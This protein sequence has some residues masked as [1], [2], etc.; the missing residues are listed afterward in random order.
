MCVLCVCTG[1]MG[2]QGEQGPQGLEGEDGDQGAC[3]L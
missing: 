2:L 3:D 1:P